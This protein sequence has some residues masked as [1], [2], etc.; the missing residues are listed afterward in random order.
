MSFLIFITGFFIS[1]LGFI[2]CVAAAY[3]AV[4][5]FLYAFAF[6]FYKIICITDPQYVEFGFKRFLG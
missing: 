6:I 3:L 2:A 1:A 5:S 4:V